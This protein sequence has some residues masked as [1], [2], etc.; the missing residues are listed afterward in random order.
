[1]EKQYLT[2]VAVDA[3]NPDRVLVSASTPPKQ[4]DDFEGLSSAVYRRMSDGSWEKCM[5]GMPD[6][7]GLT[8]PMIA[9][10]GPI[11][12]RFVAIANRGI[13]RTIDYGDSWKKI[14]INWPDE[15]TEQHPRAIA[16]IER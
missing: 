13:F 11:S 15:F 16:L 14:T 1:M 12:G 8:P 9:A 4:M 2:S 6:E 10:N 3:A 7:A 5:S